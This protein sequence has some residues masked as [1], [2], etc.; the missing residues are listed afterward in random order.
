MNG[1]NGAPQRPGRSG[2]GR[3]L[4]CWLRRAQQELRPLAAL[5]SENLRGFRAKLR[6]FQRFRRFRTCIFAANASNLRPIRWFFLRTAYKSLQFPDEPRKE[7]GTR[8]RK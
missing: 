4:V 7:G 1:T 6:N 8:W 5:K 3:S 2:L